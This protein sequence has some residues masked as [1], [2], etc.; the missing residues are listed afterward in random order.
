MSSQTDVPS[1]SVVQFGIPSHLVNDKRWNQ[2]K[3]QKVSKSSRKWIDRFMECWLWPRGASYSS[4]PVEVSIPLGTE[5]VLNRAPDENAHPPSSWDGSLSALDAAFPLEYQCHAS[6]RE[7]AGRREDEKERKNNKPEDDGFIVLNGGTLASS[8]PYEVRQLLLDSQVVLPDASTREEN[9]SEEVED[10][11]VPSSGCR[12]SSQPM[13]YFS[14]TLSFV[15]VARPLQQRDR[16]VYMYNV[17]LG[18]VSAPEDLERKKK[19]RV[20]KSHEHDGT[21]GVE[22]CDG[23]DSLRGDEVAQ[24]KKSASGRL[25]SGE[26]PTIRIFLLP[27]PESLRS[28][29]HHQTGSSNSMADVL[30]LLPCH[31]RAVMRQLGHLFQPRVIGLERA[32]LSE[33]GAA[34]S[35]SKPRLESHQPEQVEVTKSKS[36]SESNGSPRVV[37]STAIAEI[38][39]LY[40][41]YDFLTVEEHDSILKE[42]QARSQLQLQY[43]QRRRVAHFNRRFIYGVNQV[44]QEGVE[45]NPNP[46]FFT[47]IQRRLHNEDPQVRMEGPLPDFGSRFCDQLTVNYYD[48][49]DKEGRSCG[50]APHVD[51]HSAFMDQIFIVSLGSYT[52]MEFRRW[53]TPPH[54]AAATPV[55]L[56]P[57]S[58]VIMSDEARYG[59][60]HAILEKRTDILSEL[61]PPFHR[62]DRVSLTWRVARD[63]P[64]HKDT[65]PFPALC[66]GTTSTL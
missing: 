14:P 64:H 51:A 57:R 9:G 17:P 49:S 3:L 28:A 46:D 2:K 54:M 15:M 23:V 24:E 12:S 11:A 16:L 53:D 29:A 31:C 13:L 18:A 66:D 50:I 38:P 47:V 63:G 21:R 58:L 5:K 30:F 6:Q 44:D 1:S 26:I 61:L 8:S 19:H 20:E 25:W 10:A 32:M 55:Y 60:E 65:C 45:V 59:W 52:L 35:A 4:V 39:G 42:M 62:S 48:Y 40:V 43:L 27:V 22:V 37:Q 56:E 34:A 33:A 7:N 41:V 36:L